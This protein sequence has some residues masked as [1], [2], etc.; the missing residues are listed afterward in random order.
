MNHALTHIAKIDRT[1]H[2]CGGTIKAGEQYRQIRERA[3]SYHEA[4]HAG[5]MYPARRVCARCA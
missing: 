2:K 1:C 4:A 5:T 3:V